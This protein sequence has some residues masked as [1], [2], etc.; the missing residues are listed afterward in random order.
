MAESAGPVLEVPCSSGVRRYIFFQVSDGLPRL[1][2]FMA[3]ARSTEIPE[4]LTPFRL[5]NSEI[6]DQQDALATGA[7]LIVYNRWMFSDRE[8]EI[9]DSRFSPL[10]EGFDTDDS[11]WIWR[12]GE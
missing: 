4:N 5:D 3:R 11:L 7:K 8:R 6:P 9:F 2:N 1:V 12:S 10:F